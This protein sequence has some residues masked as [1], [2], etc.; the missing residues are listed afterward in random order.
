MPAKQMQVVYCGVDLS[1]FQTAD[2]A[3]KTTDP[4]ILWVGRVRKTK[5]VDLAVA[6]FTEVLKAEPTARLTIAGTGDYAAELQ[7]NITARG[8][9][10]SITLTGYLSEVQLREQMQQAWVLTYPSPKE[11]W[12]LCVIEAAACGT[13]SVASNS[14]GLC[15]AVQDE[16]TGFLVPHGN[17]PALTEKLLQLLRD[18]PLRQRMGAAALEWARHLNWDRTATEALAVLQA[19]AKSK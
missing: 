10:R 5:G 8:L 11:G 15:E 2:A 7:R 9:D 6:A 17:I 3:A 12:G 1:L 16:K 14:P 13:P 19:A 4:S 18:P